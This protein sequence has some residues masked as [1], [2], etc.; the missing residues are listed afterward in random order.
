MSCS[1]GE[2]GNNAYFLSPMLVPQGMQP[3]AVAAWPTSM[4]MGMTMGNMGICTPT[5]ATA[6]TTTTTT[7]TSTITGRQ[8]PPLRPTPSIHAATKTADINHTSTSLGTFNLSTHAVVPPMYR[9]IIPATAHGSM[10]ACN[11]PFPTQSLMG[12]QPIQRLQPVPV[13]FIYAE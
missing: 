7:T 9:M 12:F 5:C 13:F 2:N 4:G 3:V 1:S 8:Y 10:A 11:N 6:A